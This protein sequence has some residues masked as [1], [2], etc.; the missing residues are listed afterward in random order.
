M[1]GDALSKWIEEFQVEK[2]QKAA[3]R[4]QGSLFDK[5]ESYRKSFKK[6]MDYYDPQNEQFCKTEHLFCE[7]FALRELYA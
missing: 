6:E 2:V 4:S 5:K 1:N 3:F 7:L